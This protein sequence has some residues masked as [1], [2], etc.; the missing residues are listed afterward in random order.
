MA[1][2]D[3]NRG[4]EEATPVEAPTVATQETKPMN[5]TT[6]AAPVAAP[7]PNDERYRLVPDKAIK[8]DGSMVKRSD[9]MKALY[10]DKKWSRG[11][12]RK[13]ISEITGKDIKFQIVYAATKGLKGGPDKPAEAPASAPA[14]GTAA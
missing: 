3:R 5:D 10:V 11:Q 2:K 4:Q 6:N 1:R 8:G 9:Y 12:I 7:A 14:E 13:H